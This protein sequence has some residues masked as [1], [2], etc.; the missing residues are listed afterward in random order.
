[1][2]PVSSVRLFVLLSSLAHVT[3]PDGFDEAWIVGGMNSV[4]LAVDA[5]GFGHSTD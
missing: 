1:V 3:L 5:T 2:I 4:V